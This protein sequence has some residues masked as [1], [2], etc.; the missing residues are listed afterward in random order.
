MGWREFYVVAGKMSKNKRSTGF[1]GRASL[2]CCLRRHLWAGA[3]DCLSLYFGC[4]NSSRRPPWN[5]LTS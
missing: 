5:R 4:A 2:L 1:S 3:V